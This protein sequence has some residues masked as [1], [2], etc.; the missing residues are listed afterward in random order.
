MAPLRPLALRGLS[1]AALQALVER[2]APGGRVLRYRPL[3]GGVSA[4]V[5]GVWLQAR[6]GSRQV[7]VVRSYTA[8]WHRDDV[9][10]ATREFRVLEEL[11]RYG[12]P[13]PRALLLEDGP[14]PFGAP[15]LVT[16]RLPGR[17]RLQVLD[18]D[19]YVRQLA[20]TLVE[21]HRLPTDGF[22]FLPDQVHLLSR[23]LRAR[24][25][26]ADPLEPALR[27][28]VLAAWPSVC[29]SPV[30]HSVV[31]GDYWPG[32]VLWRRGRL[33]GVVDWE[34]ARLG[35]PSRDVAICRGDLTL[36]FGV[37]A[38]DAFLR[39]YEAAA[40]HRLDAMP[41]WDLL[42]STLA[43]PEVDHW[44]PGWRA[45]GRFDLTAESAREG[46]RTLAHA[47]LARMPAGRISRR[48]F[49]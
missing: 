14:G 19:D 48:R 37:P 35:D 21:L 34:D 36:L 12:F 1:G 11:G 31:H 17:P 6:D 32:N 24:V 40:G 27:E 10:V 15:T 33:S 20:A 4:S 18:L 49:D 5:Y 29:A 13:A 44:T 3:R 16:S 22:G 23:A 2:L 26:R 39:A 25:L 28:T 43:L 8:N 38:A 41:F 47:A 46:F 9:D 45:F 30:G 42:T 7:V